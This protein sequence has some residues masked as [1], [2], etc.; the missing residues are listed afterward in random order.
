MTAVLKSISRA[1]VRRDVER[2]AELEAA[3]RPLLEELD[4]LKAAFR[5]MGDGEYVGKTH[6][7]VVSTSARA[8]LDSAEVKA[9]LSPA[10]YVACTVVREVTR[11]TV[12]EV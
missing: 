6:K 12:K 3:V 7:V 1:A 10:D 11:V 5:E 2:M 9:R 8:I 4:A